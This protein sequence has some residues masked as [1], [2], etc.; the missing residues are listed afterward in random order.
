MENT[1]TT[2]TIRLMWFVNIDDDEKPIL[3]HFI[4]LVSII[5]DWAHVKPRKAE[6]MVKKLC[7]ESIAS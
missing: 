3:F 6:I 1:I 5:R 4:E 2:S 7:C